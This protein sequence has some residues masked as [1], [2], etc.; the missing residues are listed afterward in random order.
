MILEKIKSAN[1]CPPII[2]FD[3]INFVIQS[4]KGELSLSQYDD[5][6]KLKN[7]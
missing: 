1:L 3:D 4:E 2:S 5:Y 6:I 7:L